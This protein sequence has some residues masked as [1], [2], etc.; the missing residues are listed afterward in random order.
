VLQAA[1]LP[2][3]RGEA[4]G[5]SVA[6]TLVSRVCPNCQQT[7]GFKEQHVCAIA[8]TAEQPTVTDPLI[9]AVL[10]ERYKIESY[11]SSGGMGIVYKARHIV[12]DKPIAVKILR[13]AQDSDAQQRFLLEAKSACHIGHEHIVDI[14]DFGVLEDGRPYL[15]MEFLLGKSLEAVIR[16]GPLPPRR[17]CRIGEQI[18]RGLQAVHEKEILH[19][20][21][22]PGNIFLLDRQKRDFV[23]ILDFGIAKIMA[24]ERAT[25]SE[26]GSKPLVNMRQTTQG[27]VLG[28]PEY[29]SPEQAAGEPIDA[30]VDQYAL[31]CILYEMLTGDVPFRGNGPMSTLMKHLTEKPVPPREARPDLGIPES[32]ERIVLKA[33]AQNRDGRYASMEELA[34]ALMSEVEG[35]TSYLGENSAAIPAISSSWSGVPSN[36]VGHLSGGQAAS[37]MNGRVPASSVADT[38]PRPPVP[39]DAR[40]PWVYRAVGAAAGLVVLGTAMLLMWFLQNRAQTRQQ[41]NLARL[42]AERPP[43]PKPPVLPPEPVA[44]KPAEDPG[45]DPAKSKNGNEQAAGSPEASDD[46]TPLRL[47][48][49]NQSPV[50]ITLSCLGQKPAVV[51]VHDTQ[52][53]RLPPSGV[54][55]EATAPGYAARGFSAAEVR[56][57]AKKGKGKSL[58]KLEPSTVPS[59]SIIKSA[60]KK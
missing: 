39:R 25:L 36:Q 4:A 46:H 48:F 40:S 11:L 60:G 51:E 29:L 57:M 22:K 47:Q 49:T 28:T 19:R 1:A 33:M 23:K 31:G 3:A 13:E 38:L 59:L 54:R 15:V 58:I 2:E 50:R 42:A 26:N 16:E 45:N 34:Q 18:A 43:A 55:C 21:L 27:T 14:T 7:Y 56:K 6:A 17:V 12:L 35:S 44:A 5:M 30:R 32:L 53:M 20:D 37:G 9:G 8:P 41:R 52:A 24:G 10:G